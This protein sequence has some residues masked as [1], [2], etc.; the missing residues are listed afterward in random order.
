M[1]PIILL[2]DCALGANK[3]KL[4]QYFL[5]AETAV[6][7]PIHLIDQTQVPGTFIAYFIENPISPNVEISLKVFCTVPFFSVYKVCPKRSTDLYSELETK[8]LLRE[9]TPTS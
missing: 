3:C 7:L 5:E 4:V 1:Q 2:E 6:Q 8:F 9:N